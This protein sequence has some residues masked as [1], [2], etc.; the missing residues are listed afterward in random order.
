MSA[1]AWSSAARRV[2][3]SEPLFAA[4]AS[5]AGLEGLSEPP[6]AVYM[7]IG[8]CTRHRM[9]VGLPIDVLGMLLP[10]ER[11]R[12]AVG[13]ERL[14]V[15]VA[16]A[17]AA[18]T[19]FPDDEVEARAVAVEG[20]LARVREVRELD[21]LE[22]IRAS[23]L[24]VTEGFR[25][26]LDRITERAGDE[27]NVYMHRQTADVVY[28]H[29]Q[30]GGLLKLGWTVDVNGSSGGYRDEVAFDRL[31]E[32][33]S[34][35]RPGFAY[36]R[37]GRALDDRRPKVSPYVGVDPGRRIYLSETERVAAKLRRAPT[38]VGSG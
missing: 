30:L 34:G 27:G 2:V 20:L 7:G 24:H 18:S 16:D 15:L 23:T 29:E 11:L 37:C 1:L 35:A 31:V 13:A 28:L 33:W 32:P 3:A 25:A 36:V 38:L 17:H 19:G 22:I 9:A 26:V 6:A 5:E 21:R 4:E 14:V 8:L 12:A 10:A